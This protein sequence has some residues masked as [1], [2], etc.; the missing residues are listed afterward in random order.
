MKKEQNTENQA[1][2]PLHGEEMPYFPSD[3]TP[4]AQEVFDRFVCNSPESWYRKKLTVEFGTYDIMLI[5][6]RESDESKFCTNITSIRIEDLKK[7]VTILI[8]KI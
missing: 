2:N 6:E 5:E 8:E 1:I 7:L 3:N 4:E